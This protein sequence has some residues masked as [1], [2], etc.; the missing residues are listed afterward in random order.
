MVELEGTLNE[1]DKLSVEKEGNAF[2]Q[3]ASSMQVDRK[4]V[5]SAGKGQAIGMKVLQ[6]VKPGA[7]VFKITE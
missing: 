6:A 7:E 3:T 1:G 4:P 5:Q 2:E